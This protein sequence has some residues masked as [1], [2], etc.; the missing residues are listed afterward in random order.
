MLSLTPKVIRFFHENKIFIFVVPHFSHIVEVHC[1]DQSGHGSHE[2]GVRWTY[3]WTFGTILY[4]HIVMVITVSISWSVP[5]TSILELPRNVEPV[6]VISHPLQGGSTISLIDL[7]EIESWRHS[8]K[9]ESWH[10]PE[11]D[12]LSDS[13]IFIN[14][15]S[16]SEVKI[17]IWLHWRCL[18]EWLE[19]VSWV[20]WCSLQSNNSLN[21]FFSKD[22]ETKSSSNV[23][24]LLIFSPIYI[25]LSAFVM[26]VMISRGPV[27]KGLLEPNL[28]IK[29]FS[30]WLSPSVVVFIEHIVQFNIISKWKS[31]LIHMWWDIALLNNIVWSDLSD[32]HINQ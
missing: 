16:F 8:E 19:L 14:D 15:I 32:M 4:V 12:P 17:G 25:V 13:S 7:K 30:G 27:S 18:N 2:E 10:F 1:I 24:K 26:V 23:R 6:P 3:Y 9:H 21:W 28:Y 29:K 5:A 20:C 22:W 31:D 11:L